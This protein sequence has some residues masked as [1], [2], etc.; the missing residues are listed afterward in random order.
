ML[1]LAYPPGKAPCLFEAAVFSSTSVRIRD[2]DVRHG[3]E[4]AQIEDEEV[5]VGSAIA[6][7]DERGA[8]AGHIRHVA[9]RVDSGARVVPRVDGTES[10]GGRRRVFAE[11]EKLNSE[12]RCRSKSEFHFGLF[13]LLA[14]SSTYAAGLKNQPVGSSPV[15]LARDATGI[16]RQVLRNDAQDQLRSARDSEF[17]IET[18]KVRIDSVRR[19]A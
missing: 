2:L 11:A 7:A 9:G 1:G 12:D 3:G 18:L 4:R 19:D 13:L 10:H 6:A 5:P 14:D 17:R 16:E 8:V 15:V